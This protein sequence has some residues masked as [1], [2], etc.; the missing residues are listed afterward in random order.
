MEEKIKEQEREIRTYRDELL[1]VKPSEQITDSQVE[2]KYS[3]LC[4]SIRAWVD[5]RVSN[6]EAGGGDLSNLSNTSTEPHL[7]TI[8]Q[9][10]PASLESLVEAK[11][12]SMLQQHLLN[13]KIEFWGLGEVETRMIHRA[14][15]SMQTLNPPR[16][17][18]KR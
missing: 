3:N 1:N 16:G 9:E 18:S 8:I 11:V 5:G 7:R 15:S 12:H 10:L 17:M 2:D 4:E 14:T 6:F 13:R